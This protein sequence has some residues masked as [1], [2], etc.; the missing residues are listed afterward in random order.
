MREPRTWLAIALGVLFCIIVVFVTSC[1]NRKVI[2]SVDRHQSLMANG[3]YE[4]TTLEDGSKYV[5]ILATD[6]CMAILYDGTE[7]GHGY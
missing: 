6:M 1:V 4:F 7:G 3:C 2:R 5:D